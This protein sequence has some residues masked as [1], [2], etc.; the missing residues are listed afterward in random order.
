[1]ARAV[2]AHNQHQARAVIPGEQ[3]RNAELLAALHGTPSLASLSAC[4]LQELSRLG[5][6]CTC[7]RGEILLGPQDD[8][9]ALL[10][11]LSGAVRVYRLSS[12][13][14]EVTVAR[15]GTGA[16]CGLMFLEPSVTPRS[17]FVAAQDETRVF[18]L[19]PDAFRQFLSSRPRL[20]TEMLAIV[21]G[22]LEEARDQIEELAFH[23]MKTRLARTLARLAADDSG[24]LVLATHAQLATMVGTR[25]EEVTKAL[26]HFREQGLVWYRPHARGI[27]IP[28]VDR[29]AAY[30]REA[31]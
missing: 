30:C 4:E 31:L 2:D 22:R 23:D 5:R 17:F 14:H 20:A 12:S 27:H 29:L 24:R 16:V 10:V 8:K 19:D 28:D 13:G 1:M 6:F 9:G 21:G 26:R 15:W 3:A 7:S 18:R 25:Q 11:V